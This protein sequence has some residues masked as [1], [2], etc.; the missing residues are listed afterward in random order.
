[1]KYSDIGAKVSKQEFVDFLNS[2]NGGQ[3]FHI[4]GYVNSLGEVSD[5]ILRFGVNYGRIK[6]RDSEFL[7]QVVTGQKTF[8]IKV[9]HGVWVPNALLSL[10]QMITNEDEHDVLVKATYKR[11]DDS[12]GH[13]F[14]IN[15]TGLMSLFDVEKFSSRKSA[16]KTQVMLSYELNSGHPLVVAAIGA[17]DLTGTLLGGLSGV[18]GKASPTDH[19]AKYIKEAK[20]CYSSEKDGVTTWYLRDVLGV[21]KIVRVPSENKFSA[22]IPLNA[23]K[24]AIRSQFL[25]S[26]QYR[27]FILTEGKF[28][29]VT[30]EGQSILMGEDIYFALPQDVKMVCSN[31]EYN[32][33]N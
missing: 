16:D 11:G 26:N 24:E 15:I 27:Q 5:H 17:N 12:K 28:Q 3:F 6:E 7:S 29:S 31:K 32:G 2:V 14:R 21:S 22:S 9:E 20:C 33:N 8:K 13:D 1:M 23:V 19:T 25:L 10:K 30:I 4:R 18:G